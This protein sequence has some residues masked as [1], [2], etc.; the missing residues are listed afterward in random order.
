MELFVHIRVIRDEH[1]SL[2]GKKA[3]CI[4]T[5]NVGK[6]HFTFKKRLYLL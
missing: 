1:D 2:V 4:L 3:T 5:M 6:V